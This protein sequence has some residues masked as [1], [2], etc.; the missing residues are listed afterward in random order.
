MFLDLVILRIGLITT[1]VTMPIVMQRMRKKRIGGIDVHKKHKP[2]IQ[3]MCGI[4]VLFGLVASNVVAM[5]LVPEKTIEL[6]SFLITA[7]IAGA[8]GAIDDMKPLNA[9]VKPFLTL[10]SF[11]MGMYGTLSTLGGVCL[12][13]MLSIRFSAANSRLMVA[14][15]APSSSRLS[16]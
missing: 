15:A 7:L 9:K 8:V 5:V 6:T 1:F 2:V 16:M 3:E 13:P 11:S 14:L 12:A 10:F 4:Q